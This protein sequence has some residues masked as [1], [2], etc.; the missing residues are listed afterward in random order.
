MKS[1]DDI[2]V[3]T[4]SSGTAISATPSITLIDRKFGIS[5]KPRMLTQDEI[6]LLR[7]SEREIIQVTR[8]ILAKAP[9]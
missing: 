5:P 6:N 2:T 9:I 8:E 4:T 7:Q 1:S 3:L